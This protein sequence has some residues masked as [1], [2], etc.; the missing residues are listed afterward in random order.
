MRVVHL[1]QGRELLWWLW[2]AA[3]VEP[4]PYHTG[5]KVLELTPSFPL[6]AHTAV[7]G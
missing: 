2:G 7:S 3:G 6:Y 5:W 1:G 4:G